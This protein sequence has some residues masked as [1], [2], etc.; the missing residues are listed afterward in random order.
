MRIDLGLTP[1]LRKEL[2]DNLNI[3]IN[4]AAAVDMNVELE[5]A[6][7]VNVTGAHLLLLLADECPNIEVFCHNSSAYVNGDRLGYIEERLYQGEVDWLTEYQK[8]LRLTKRDIK[9]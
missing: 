1:E 4:G 5:K 2:T 8:S 3:I 9:T 7:R 6:V